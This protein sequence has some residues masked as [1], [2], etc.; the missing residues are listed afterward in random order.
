[1]VL[2]ANREVAS[3]LDSPLSTSGCRPSGKPAALPAR[4]P[5]GRESDSQKRLLTEPSAASSGHRGSH[6]IG[7]SASYGSGA[8]TRLLIVVARLL[9]SPVDAAVFVGGADLWARTTGFLG[10]DG[11]LAATTT[12]AGHCPRGYVVH[13]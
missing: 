10:A 3:R 2:S 11:S 5:L 1:M 8:F 13:T 7:A 12:A 9:V 6:S 4:C